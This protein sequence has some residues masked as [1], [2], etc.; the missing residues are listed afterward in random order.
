M[1]ERIHSEPGRVRLHLRGGLDSE[2]SRGM[3]DSLAALAAVEAREVVIDLSHVTFIDGSGIG[4][5]SFLFKRLAARGRRLSLAGVSGQPLAMLRHLG[6]TTALGIDVAGG[7]RSF[8]S[9]P[10]SAWAR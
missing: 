8:F 6:L 4:A 5:L 7:R 3:R 10:G 2:A 9:L 1:F